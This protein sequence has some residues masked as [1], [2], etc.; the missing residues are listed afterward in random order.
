MGGMMVE[1]LWYYLEIIL[2]DPGVRLA[3]VALVIYI[4]VRFW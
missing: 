2:K 1:S 3:Y 4:A